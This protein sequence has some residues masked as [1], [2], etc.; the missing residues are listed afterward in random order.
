MQIEEQTQAIRKNVE[1]LGKHLLS[2]D[3]FM[4][5]LGGQ[6]GTTVN[7]YNNAYKEFKK[8]D[9]DIMRVSGTGGKIEIETIEKPQSDI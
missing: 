3:E 2:Y 5:R 4:K 8:I 7:T 9:K 1:D 6:I